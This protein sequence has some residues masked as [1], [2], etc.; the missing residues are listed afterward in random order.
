MNKPDELSP[1]VLNVAVSPTWA[2]HFLRKLG[3]HEVVVAHQ[4]PEDRPALRP[5]DERALLILLGG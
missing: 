5:H 1:S 3:D 4:T 2:A